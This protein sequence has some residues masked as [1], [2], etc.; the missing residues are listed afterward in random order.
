MYTF[1]ICWYMFMH[2]FV[3]PRDKGEHA[4]FHTSLATVAESSRE[5]LLAMPRDP[6]SFRGKIVY[7]LEVY[8]RLYQ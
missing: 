8:V 7:L 3:Y 4:K 6:N 1:L 2:I 5:S